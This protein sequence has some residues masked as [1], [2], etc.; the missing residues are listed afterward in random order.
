MLRKCN[1]KHDTILTFSCNGNTLPT[2]HRLALRNGIEG[3]SRAQ[4][5]VRSRKPEFSERTVTRDGLSGFFVWR[6]EMTRNA[7][8][9][10]GQRFNHWTIVEYRGSSQWL[11]RCDCGFERVQPLNNIIYG[12]AS[13]S[14]GCR[15]KGSVLAV[16]KPAFLDRQFNG[17]VIRQRSSDGYFDATAMCKIGG[18]LVA[19]WS[20]LQSTQ[21]YLDSL[22]TVTG[23]PITELVV[24]NQG[25]DHNSQ[26]T[27]IHPRAAMRLAQWISPEF[28][29]L[30]DGWVLDLVEGKTQTFGPQKRIETQAAP[31]PVEKNLGLSQMPSLEVAEH[32][33][34]E[35]ERKTKAMR[36]IVSGLRKAQKFLAFAN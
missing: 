8:N 31:V 30:V 27:W 20:R 23:I 18:K 26:G 33:L 2:W 11:V 5:P 25:G 21:A 13:K 22:S 6:M 35:L 16:S 1:E 24:V 12:Q 36:C 9:R 4:L 28:A 3:R 19:D 17:S 32:E 14:C 29:V 15:G 34:K 7:V 10:A